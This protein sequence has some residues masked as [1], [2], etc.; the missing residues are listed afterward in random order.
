MLSWPA[1]SHRIGLQCCL[2]TRLIVSMAIAPDFRVVK[3]GC[4]VYSMI[5]LYPNVRT[6]SVF[7]SR[8]QELLP[9]FVR[10]PT[11]LSGR[12]MGYRFATPMSIMFKE[13]VPTL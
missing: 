1:R 13:K 3:L 7:T 4:L 10:E 8:I 12:K 2:A 6:S 5:V 11:R 9:R